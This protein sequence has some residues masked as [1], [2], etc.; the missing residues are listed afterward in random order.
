MPTVPD[1]VLIINPTAGR[2]KAGKQVPEIR[3]LLGPKC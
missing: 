3:R 1:A 2:G